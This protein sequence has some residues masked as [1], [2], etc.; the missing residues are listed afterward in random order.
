M[1]MDDDFMVQLKK[2]YGK[3]NA[4]LLLG[5]NVWSKYSG[6]TTATGTGLSKSGWYNMAN[7]SSVS[8][9]ETNYLQRKVGFYSSAEI[10]YDR[11]LVLSLSGR[12]DGT[13]V[14]A[15]QNTWYPYG[16]AALGFIFSELFKDNLKKV[17]NFAKARISYA[18][19]GNDNVTPYQTATPYLQ[20]NSTNIYNTNIT[21]PY[22]GQNGFLVNPSEGNPYLK[23]ELQKEFEVGLETKMLDNRIGLEASYFDRRM[24]NGLVQGVTLASSSGYGSTTVNSAKINTKGLEVLLNVTPVRTRDF[25]WD[26]TVNFTRLRTVVK[27]IVPGTDLFNVGFTYAAAGKP[28]GMLYG[29]T[30]ARD[31]KNN[32]LLDDNG[33]PY[34]DGSENFLGTVTPDW[35]GGITNTF[36]YKQFG[37]SFFF[38]TRQGGVLQNVDEY[39]NLFYGVSKA[40]EN[41]QDRVIKGISES[42]GT[43]N[44]VST[45]AQTYF[46]TIS[47]IT[48]A[49]IQKASYIKLRNVTFSYNVDH[50]LLKKTP[51]KD[52]MVTFTGRNLWIHKDAG[53]TGSDPESNSTYG[54]SN[55]DLGVY[56][57]GT[58]TSRSVGCSLKLTF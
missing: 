3:F 13:S 35:T 31:A 37:L 34:S 57:F 14:L 10:D 17:V 54:T 44:T 55:G 16:S 33:L 38:D 2:E 48:E 29:T 24:S 49:Q 19:V 41:R 7:A 23:N 18:S 52:M 5:N 46:Q 9:S 53:F 32:L 36:R 45:K 51:F 8:Y 4:S 15:T 50:S 1:P 28:Y 39:Y 21:F 43:A 47:Y 22:S 40:T 6:Y 58:P 12:Y 30:Y 20:V 56:T 26:M 42:T 11:L 27:Q 25:S